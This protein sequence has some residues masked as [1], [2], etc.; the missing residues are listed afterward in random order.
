MNDILDRLDRM[1]RPHLLLSAARIG[2]EDYRRETHLPRILGHGALPR[3]LAAL[4]RLMEIETEM[5]DTRL[6]EDAAYS[7]MNHV[8]VMIAVIGEARIVR[9]TRPNLSSAASGTG[10]TA[11]TVATLH[12]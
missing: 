1:R 3:H 5:N 2:A 4:A 9:A 10:H 8:D 7:T 6:A 11:V 12:L